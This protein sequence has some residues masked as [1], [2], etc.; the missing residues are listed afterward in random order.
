MLT[1]LDRPALEEIAGE[2]ALKVLSASHIEGGA[3]NTSY[4]IT[5]ETGRFV[6]TVLELQDLAFA[7]GYG[8]FLQRMVAHGLPAPLPRRTLDGRWSCAYG[9]KPIVLTSHVQGSSTGALNE[10]GLVRLGTLLAKIHDSGLVRDTPPTVRLTEDDLSWLSASSADPFARWA[11]A[12]HGQTVGAVQGGEDWRLTHGDPF[13]DNIILTSSD[14]LVLIDWE[15][16]ASDLPAIDLAMATLSHCC[17]PGLNRSRVECLVAGYAA[18]SM[19]PIPVT[20]ILRTAAYAS[21]VVAYRRYRRYL[22]GI[23]S[24]D[25]YLAMQKLVDL[26]SVSALELK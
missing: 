8:A 5:A 26:L 17:S 24:P 13:R 18:H 12:R 7:E 25:T 9:G 19:S 4:L 11:L 22:A 6:A 16:A 21:L 14:K 20:T 10:T 2:F 1:Q 15:E 23:A 3:N